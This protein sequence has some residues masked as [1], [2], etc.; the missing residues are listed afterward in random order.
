[1][2]K[3]K[4]L[5]ILTIKQF[6]RDELEFIYDVAKDMEQYSKGEKITDLLKGKILATLFFEAST[7]TRMSFESAMNRL[8][9]RVISTAD[10]FKFS[11]VTK[12]ETLSDSGRVIG[13]YADVIAM[14]HPVIGSVAELSEGTK[15][16]VINAGDGP[17]QHPTQALLDYYTIKKEFGKVDGLKIALVGD[18][19][20]GRTV[21]S[22]ADLMTH[23]DVEFYFVAP[24]EL[25]MPPEITS[26]LKEQGKKITEVKKL[27]DCIGEIDVLYDTRIQKERFEDHNE[28]LRLKDVFQI[29][30][31]LMKQAK[32]KMI[33][34][35][36][37]PRVD[38]ILSEVDADPRARYFEQAINGVPVRMA[39][40]ALVLG[41]VK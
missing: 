19:K 6:G 38:E 37:L 26:E 8:G 11:S 41:K 34:M 9:G 22:L 28:Y 7:R 13:G 5:H 10:A 30:M 17:G 4:G 35:H 23:Y 39:L 16:P 14:R 12:G 29:N 27:E 31:G 2:Q 3:F 20:Y 24:D 15:T 25:K 21:H 1:M 40:L 32:E 18:L 36:P 33:V